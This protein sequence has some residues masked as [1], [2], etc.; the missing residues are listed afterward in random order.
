MDGW[1]PSQG[2]GRSSI[3]IA[4]DLYLTISLDQVIF[5][6]ADLIAPQGVKFFHVTQKVQEF[7]EVFADAEGSVIQLDCRRICHG[8]AHIGECLIRWFIIEVD[9]LCCA[10]D[11]LIVCTRKD[12]KEPNVVTR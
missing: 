9:D 1:N 3:D 6:N 7:P 4:H 5:V 8:A 11:D 10:S 12:S 2:S